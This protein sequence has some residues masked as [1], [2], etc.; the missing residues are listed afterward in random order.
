MGNGAELAQQVE[1]SKNTQTLNEQ[2]LIPSHWDMRRSLGRGDQGTK[3]W[4]CGIGRHFG[5]R[6]R[7][8]WRRATNLT[9]PTAVLVRLALRAVSVHIDVDIHTRM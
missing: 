2:L 4:E 6:C 5:L 8:T 1:T 7:D 3:T 9:S